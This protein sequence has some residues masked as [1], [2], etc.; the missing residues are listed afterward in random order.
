MSCRSKNLPVYVRSANLLLLLHLSSCLPRRAILGQRRQL[1]TA[2]TSALHTPP[3][4]ASALQ[5]M[6]CQCRCHGA[7][8]RSRA[9]FAERIQAVS[10]LLLWLA[11]DLC[12]ARSGTR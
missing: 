6:A 4:K 3:K 5:G 1:R 2:A 11:E 9:L 8:D 12:A 10:M 7:R